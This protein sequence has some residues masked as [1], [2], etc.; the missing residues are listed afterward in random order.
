MISRQY[1]VEIINKIKEQSELQDEICAVLEKMSPGSYVDAFVYSKYEDLVLKL[2][3]HIFNLGDDDILE[4]WIYDLEYGK[5]Y[6]EGCVFDE[7]TGENIDIS[8]TE[9]LYDYLVFLSEK[10]SNEEK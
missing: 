2:L 8:T 4:Y 3:K 7:K 6:E 5:K 9:K 10:Y 1:F